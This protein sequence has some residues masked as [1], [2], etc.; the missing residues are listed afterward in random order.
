MSQRAIL[1]TVG[2]LGVTAIA[3]YFIQQSLKQAA[4]EAVK[5]NAPAAGYQAGKGAI[6]AVFANVET[7][8]NK[9]QTPATVV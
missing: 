9:T 7:L 4:S 8:V 6:D 5:T 2:L 1:L 3:V